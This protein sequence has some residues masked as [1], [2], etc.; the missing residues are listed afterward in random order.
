MEEKKYKFGVPTHDLGRDITY[1]DIVDEIPRFENG[2]IDVKA[3]Y[4]YGFFKKY[5]QPT[6]HLSPWEDLI[7]FYRYHT[8]KNKQDLDKWLLTFTPEELKKPEIIEVKRKSLEEV[9][10]LKE[11]VR[12]FDL[13][14]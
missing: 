9:E 12:V 5:A 6:I 2:K 7:E 10:W 8:V 13:E 4:A 11:T 14:N 1:A 3:Y